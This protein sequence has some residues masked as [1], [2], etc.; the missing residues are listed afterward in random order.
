MA[1]T[2]KNPRHSWGWLRKPS[3]TTFHLNILKLMFSFHN[4][5]LNLMFANFLKKIDIYGFVTLVETTLV[6]VIVV[7][8]GTFLKKTK[9][10]DCHIIDLLI[11]HSSVSLEFTKMRCSMAQGK[12]DP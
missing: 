1:P 2:I 7:R 11:F 8:V 6:L 10:F 4:I 12:I 9:T 5:L 3:L